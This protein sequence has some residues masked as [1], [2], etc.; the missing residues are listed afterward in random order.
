MVNTVLQEKLCIFRHIDCLFLYLEYHL[1]G[2]YISDNK[3]F[4]RMYKML[5][6]IMYLIMYYE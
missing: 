3:K 2:I 5:V 1:L 4:H 6:D